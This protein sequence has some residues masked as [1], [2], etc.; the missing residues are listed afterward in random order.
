MATKAFSSTALNWNI[1]F[2]ANYKPWFSYDYSKIA[3]ET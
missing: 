3:C 1:P 2:Y